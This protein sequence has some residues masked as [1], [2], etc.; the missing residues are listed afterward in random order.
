M[1]IV[2]GSR[3]VPMH[4]AR[5]LLGAA[6]LYGALHFFPII[7]APALLLLGVM[8]WALKG[9]PTCWT[10]G[11][12][13][14][15]AAQRARRTTSE[16][17]TSHLPTTALLLLTA[18]TAAAPAR[19]A[20]LVVIATAAVKGAMAHVPERFAAASGDQVSFSFGTA[21]FVSGKVTSGT[22]FDLV[23]LPPPR[24][25]E[26][27]EKG[28]VV[29][30]SVQL[31][32]AVQ[33]GAGVKAGAPRPA[34]DSMEA[35]RATLLAAPSLGMADPAAGA[36]SGI[37]LMRRLQELGLLDAIKAKLHVYPEGQLAMEA[38][39]RGEVALGLGLVSE[40]LPVPG[41]VM[42]GKLPEAVQLRSA[43]SVA[44]A[45]HAASP[46]AAA[47]LRAFLLGPQTKAA[48]AA[49]GFDTG[50]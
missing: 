34:I 7:G 13:E 41:A 38:V 49:Q 9:C 44:I 6:S 32:G 2:F 28:L 25:A 14:T 31:L 50:S 40:I 18:L 3:S 17:R 23:V 4:V 1:G 16:K 15:I 27:A 20:Q 10:I 8:F 33:L 11:L 47:R 30:S 21:G 26:M 36:T 22:P 45:S 42:I 46:E 37:F 12:F 48:F 19:S 24:M 35:F 39:S 29:G 43:Y 5:G